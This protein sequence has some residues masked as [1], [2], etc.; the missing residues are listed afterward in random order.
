MEDLGP[1][2]WRCQTRSFGDHPDHGL[3]LLRLRCVE[4]LRAQPDGL[5]EQV[6]AGDAVARKIRE[7]EAALAAAELDEAEGRPVLRSGKS[8][9]PGVA[10]SE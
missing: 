3:S 2:D 6:A 9:T 5:S 8:I 1:E 4:I 7:N 10:G